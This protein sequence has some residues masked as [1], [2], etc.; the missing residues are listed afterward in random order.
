MFVRSARHPRFVSATEMGLN[1]HKTFRYA[2]LVAF[3]AL[4]FAA[5]SSETSNHGD[6]PGRTDV[7][8]TAMVNPEQCIGTGGGFEAAALDAAGYRIQP[9]DQLAIDFYLN[10]EFND[11][12]SVQPDGR[13]VLRL[14]GPIQAAG[15]SSGQLSA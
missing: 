5:C 10:S 13:I 6:Q 7:G 12:V 15:L 14:V 9:G 3:C 8:Q 11:N 2:L 1:C 4:A